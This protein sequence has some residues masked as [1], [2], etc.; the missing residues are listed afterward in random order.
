VGE[1]LRDRVTVRN[2]SAR[3]RAG[4]AV[5]EELADP[6]PGRAEFA[7]GL[8]GAARYSLLLAAR[9]WQ[10]LV[11]QR[12]PLAADARPLP[13]LPA[14]GSA[15]LGIEFVP[16]R[17]GSVEFARTWLARREPL[18]LFRAL[19]ALPSRQSLLVLPR[20]YPVPELALPGH[21]VYQHGGVT[22]A[23]SVGDSEEFVGLRDYR[24]GDPLQH[25]HWKSFAR[26][27][28]PVVKEYQDEF[29][30]RHA[31]VLDTC[32]EDPG[33]Q[34]E[35]AVSVAASF[36]CTLDTQECL[37][38]LLFVGARSY[39]FTAGRGHLHA[40]GLLEI[41]AHVQPARARDLE[42]LGA[43][44]AEH[45]QRLSG[46]ILVLLGWDAAR[47]RLVRELR[48]TGLETLVLVVAAAGAVPPPA[49]PGL[50]WLQAGRVAEGLAGLHGQGVAG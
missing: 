36:A 14:A 33:A 37:L 7:R 48:A 23:T 22:F 17:R 42:L 47:Q 45:R 31:L 43:T 4:L 9:H 2:D 44:L 49:E 3:P 35:E 40:Q 39:C 29:F 30:E 19:R 28:R 13:P 24:P 12:L 32:S 38:D 25:V 50:A 18:G 41:L 46:C 26:A 1:P 15:T 10:Q 11:R 6:R 21:R 27:G 5:I 16:E 34:F 8:R 20:R